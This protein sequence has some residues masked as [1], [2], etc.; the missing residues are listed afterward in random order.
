MCPYPSPHHLL[1]RHVTV[2]VFRGHVNE[3]KYKSTIPRKFTI[4][5]VWNDT[6]YLPTVHMPITP[7]HFPPPPVFNEIFAGM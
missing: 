1:I 4:K 5:K 6:L 3:R 7:L 2:L